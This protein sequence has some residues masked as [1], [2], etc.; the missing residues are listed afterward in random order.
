MTITQTYRKDKGKLFLRHVETREDVNGKEF[1]VQ[2]QEVEFDH[3]KHIP[4]LQEKLDDI[5][6]EIT[7]LKTEEIRLFN[8]IAAIVT[9]R[10]K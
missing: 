4:Q 5:R 10:D 3:A 1:I 8:K 6:S 7:D 9:A 2:D